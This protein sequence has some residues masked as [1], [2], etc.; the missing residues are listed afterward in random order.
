MSGLDGEQDCRIPTNENVLK[1]AIAFLQLLVVNKLLFYF[2]ASGL[3]ESYR[4]EKPNIQCV[5]LCR[6]VNDCLNNMEKNTFKFRTS[7]VQGLERFS[8]L[9]SSISDLI[10]F[11]SST[12]VV[13]IG[14]AIC[15]KVCLFFCPA[16]ASTL[17]VCG[18][19]VLCHF[20]MLGLLRLW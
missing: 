5:L 8:P 18:S 16:R 17:A 12:G 2:V 1:L 11:L 14:I 10:R 7:S 15:F 4:T 19:K 9:A 3:Y 13:V 6:Y 20:S